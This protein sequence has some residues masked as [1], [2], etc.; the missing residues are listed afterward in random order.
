VLVEDSLP[1]GLQALDAVSVSILDFL[2]CL[3]DKSNL[4][5]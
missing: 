1:G 4:G 3:I 5:G 2:L